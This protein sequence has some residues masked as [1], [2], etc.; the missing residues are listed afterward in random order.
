MSQGA[1]A[2]AIGMTQAGLSNIERGRTAKPLARNVEA[3][4][5]ALNCKPGQL[6]PKTDAELREE[7]IVVRIAKL[8]RLG[9]QLPDAG[10]LRRRRAIAKKLRAFLGGRE[11]MYRRYPQLADLSVYLEVDPRS[12]QPLTLEHNG[13]VLGREQDDLPLWLKTELTLAE[14]DRIT[15]RAYARR[16]ASTAEQ[17]RGNAIIDVQEPGA[18]PRA[19]ERK[20]VK[21]ASSRRSKSDPDKPPLDRPKKRAAT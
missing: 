16:D 18:V 21:R 19:R 8:A 7:S 9:Q 10:T 17:E 11:A 12:F 5:K 14:A 20:H 1:L 15:A 13:E 3:I 6:A 4:S 2:R